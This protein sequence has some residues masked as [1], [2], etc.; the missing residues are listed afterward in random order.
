MNES[1]ETIIG[2]SYAIWRKNPNL[3]LPYLFNTIVN[4][5]LMLLFAATVIM[6]FNPF[7]GFSMS[8]FNPM[9]I[10]WPI[11]FLDIGLL[12]L[13]MI[14]TALIS[15]FFNAGAIG[16]SYKALETGR[17]SL[18]DLT[19]YGAKKFFTLFLTDIIIMVPLAVVACGL[20]LLQM[21]FPGEF[22]AIFSILAGIAIVMV[23]YSIVIGDM[24]P[25]QGIK[26][27][28]GIF[29]ENKFQ[30]TLLY[31]FTYYFLVYSIYWVMLAC[32]V[33][34]SLALFFMPMPQ[35]TSIQGIVAALMPSMWMVA[36][37]LLLAAIFYILAE[38]MILLPLI[39]LIWTAYYMS[40]TNRRR[41]V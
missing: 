34:C 12:F 27:G 20:L 22:I 14:A 5:S 7:R 15:T 8:G 11:L 24:G 26:A 33:I 37:A 32:M 3:G 17:C 25:V 30:T 6:F 18:D 36:I 1:I 23:P 16:M 21:I 9:N 2:N 29:K 13:I 35:E 38:T 41:D 10:D 40:K 19:R 28:F 39:N 4:L 31:A